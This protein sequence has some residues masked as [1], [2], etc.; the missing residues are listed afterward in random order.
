VGTL[1]LTLFTH[2]LAP[3]Q[4]PCL[5]PSAP[6]LSPVSKAP[7][8]LDLVL[9]CLLLLLMTFSDA[10]PYPC[11]LLPWRRSPSSIVAAQWLSSAVESQ[12]PGTW[13]LPDGVVK[14]T[15]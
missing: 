4:L 12:D 10:E 7:L 14:R 11:A 15:Q 3:L 8:L 13:P 2:H 6:L 5:I 1:G 9:P